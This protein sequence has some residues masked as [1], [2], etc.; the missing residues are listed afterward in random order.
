MS[1]DQ[2]D[3]EGGQQDPGEPR[4][5]GG[6]ETGPGPGAAAS[7]DNETDAP[8]IPEGYEPL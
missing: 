7:P 6:E 8:E 2:P 1:S 4:T 3:R 5:A